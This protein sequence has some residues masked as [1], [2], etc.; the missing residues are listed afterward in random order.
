[1]HPVARQVHLIVVGI[2]RG[3]RTCGSRARG[4]AKSLINKT[5][6]WQEVEH[7]YAGVFSIAY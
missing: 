4:L 6:N 5:D 3:S 2:V 7:D 1:M